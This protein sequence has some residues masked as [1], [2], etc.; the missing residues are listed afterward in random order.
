MRRAR[1][2][3]S[4]GWIA[5]RSI[6]WERRRR[7]CRF[8][9]GW[10]FATTEDIHSTFLT[11]FIRRIP[12]LISLPDLQ[13]RS[14]GEKEA[15]TL[16]FFWQEARTLSARLQLTPRLLQVLTHYVYRGNVGELKNVVKYAVASA[17]ARSP[18]SER[19]KRH[20]ARS[21]GKYHGRDAGA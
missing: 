4:P 16:Q 1:R 19:A 21:A 20:A 5:K 12:I 10:W 2:S 13:N 6:G 7:G 14:R 3:S 18:G 15:L 9:C 11:T 8:R 17:W